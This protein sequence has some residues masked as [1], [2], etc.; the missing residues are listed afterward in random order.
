MATS[1]HRREL[2]KSHFKFQI[3]GLCDPFR[4]TEDKWKKFMEFLSLFID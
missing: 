1:S 4:G 2:S 3:K